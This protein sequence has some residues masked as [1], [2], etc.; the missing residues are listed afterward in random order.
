MAFG[1]DVIQR[2]VPGLGGG[3]TNGSGGLLQGVGNLLQGGG[4][5]TNEAGTNQPATNQSPVNNLL[6]RLL[7]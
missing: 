4:G 2:F 5:K 6:N 3:G 1:K 7:K